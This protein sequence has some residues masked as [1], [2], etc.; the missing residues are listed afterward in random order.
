MTMMKVL[1]HQ[2]LLQD[3]YADLKDLGNPS[4]SEEWTVGQVLDYIR[5]A[6][7]FLNEEISELMIEIGGGRQCLKPWS[8]KY[9]TL[10]KAPFRSTSEVK[11]EAVDALCFLMNILLAAGLNHKN[12]DEEYAKVFHKNRERLRDAGY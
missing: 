11:S 5:D 2:A 4:C 1:E 10:R 8:S 3:I 6:R 12:I 7:D 9:E